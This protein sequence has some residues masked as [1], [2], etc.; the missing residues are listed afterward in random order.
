MVVY[1]VDA[2]PVRFLFAVIVMCVC[3]LVLLDGGVLALCVIYHVLCVGAVLLIVGLCI[4]FM[5]LCLATIDCSTFRTTG[6]DIVNNCWL[7]YV[8]FLV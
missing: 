1:T 8:I 7:G 6:V 3:A 2:R 5:I 4:F